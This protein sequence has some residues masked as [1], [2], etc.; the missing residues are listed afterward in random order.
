MRQTFAAGVADLRDYHDACKPQ[1]NRKPLSTVRFRLMA[2][3]AA[4]NNVLRARMLRSELC[5][6][7]RSGDS[8]I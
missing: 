6:G 8:V 1:V 5:L 7:V 4:C 3:T 2:G